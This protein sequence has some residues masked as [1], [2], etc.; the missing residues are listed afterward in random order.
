MAYLSLLQDW[1]LLLI[2]IIASIVSLLTCTTVATRMAAVTTRRVAMA[3]TIYNIFFIITRFANLFYLPYMGIFVD[4]AE[5]TGNMELLLMQLRMVVAWAAVGSIVAW[6]LLPTFVEI[7][8]RGIASLERHQSMVKV[9][10][11]LLHPS[12]WLHV[13]TSLRRPGN[14]GVSLLRLEGVP[15][16][17]LVFNVFATAV[18]TVG[19]LAAIY[20]SALHPECKRTAV[21]LSGLVNSVAAIFFSLIVDPKASLITDQA[22]NGERPERHVSIMSVFLMAGNVLGTFLAQFVL[23]PGVKV[24]ELATLALSGNEI[25]GNI[26][27]LVLFNAIVTMKASTTVSARIAA[28]LTRRVATAIAIY[29]FFFLITRIAQQIYAP[30]IG[31]IVDTAVKRGA[32]TLIEAQF[33]WIIGGATIGALL[34]WIFMPTFVEIYRKAINGME[35]FGSLPR[36]LYVTCFSFQA[37]KKVIAC[38]RPPS[39]MGVRL[40]DVRQI[41]RNFLVGNIIVISIHTIGVLAATYASAAYPDARGVTLLSAV[42]NGIATILLSIVVDPI[43][44]LITD[45]AVAEKRPLSHVKTMAVFLAAGTVLGTLL[46]QVLFLP[47]ADFIKFCSGLMGKL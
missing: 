38:L 12:R 4:K 5:R 47:A 18:W 14:F 8:R 44:A 7:Y 41:P 2:C 11:R 28:V 43:T 32:I 19:A 36:L 3:F 35:R 6:L 22:I 29:N 21:L 30:I 24:I 23:L 1:H 16:K 27:L 37:W 15:W 45:E 34:G 20:V 46:S 9:L 25:V 31:S 26:A 42:V 33:R 17:F 40:S 13:V 10:I 39:M